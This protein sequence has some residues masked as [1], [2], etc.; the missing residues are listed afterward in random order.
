MGE[1]HQDQTGRDVLRDGCGH[2]YASHAH[3]HQ[4]NRHQVQYHI[5][6]AGNDQVEQ[7]TLGIALGTKN[8]CAEVVGHGGGH[9]QK[10]DAQIERG[11]VDYVL[12][13]GHPYQKLMGHDG[14][15]YRQHRAADQSHENGGMYR[16]AYHVMALTAQ[17]SGHY[18]VGTNRQAHKQGDEQV[19][20]GGSGAYG[21]Q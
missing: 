4:D 14:T 2:R 15:E 17:I 13:R 20:Q 8:R 12:G 5:H 11:Q 3:A 18:Y 9:T 19:D 7:G 6:H 10:V 16:F 21:G 1:A